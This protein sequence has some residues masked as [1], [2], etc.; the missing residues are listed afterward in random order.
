MQTHEHAWGPS[1]VSTS[2]SPGSETPAPPIPA[3][4]SR[5]EPS[6]SEY[7]SGPVGTFVVEWQ[8]PAGF[9]PHGQSS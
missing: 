1:S 9:A 4:N 5:P 7:D 6:S 3:G 2:P 8:Q